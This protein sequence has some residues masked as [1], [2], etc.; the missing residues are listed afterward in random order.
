MNKRSWRLLALF[1]VAVFLIISA[2]TVLMGTLAMALY[3]F[4]VIRPRDPETMILLLAVSCIIV[5]TVLSRAVGKRVMASVIAIS[6]ATKE[7]AKGNFDIRIDEDFRA[8]EIR[9]IARD[10]NIMTRELSK[11]EMF[12]SDFI[13]NVSH[14]FKTPLSAIEG[15]ATLLQ[16]RNLTAEKRDAYIAGILGNTKRLTRLTGNILQL[17]RLENQEIREAKAAFSLDEQIRQVILTLETE[18]ERKELELDIELEAADYIGN[19][20]LLAQVWQNLIGNA[21][22][23]TD[24][25]GSVRVSLEK[26]PSRVTVTVAD[27]GIGMTQEAV[28]RAFEKFYQA[29]TSHA[30]KG[31]GLGLT[32]A[33]R[34]VDLHGGGIAVASE[35]G[36]GTVFTVTL[37]TP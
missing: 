20:E 3:R 33:K 31:N 28:S 32:L 37:P 6:E 16:N 36:M 23:F 17:S 29:E 11:T 14:E 13:N 19:A 1:S 10:F 26:A 25:R 15:Y 2:T 22:K 21:I 35:P 34:I 12:R 5:G 30:T 9:D 27:S 8:V 24:D 4:G 7:V 18:W